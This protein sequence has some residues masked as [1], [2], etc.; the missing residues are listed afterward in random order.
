MVSEQLYKVVQQLNGYYQIKLEDG[1][2]GYVLEGDAQRSTV[3]AP[4]AASTAANTQQTI[5]IPAVTEPAP[6]APAQENAQ[7]PVEE[8][9]PVPE[10][11]SNKVY[12]AQVNQATSFYTAPNRGNETME[13]ITKSA[14]AVVLVPSENGFYYWAQKNV[15]VDSSTVDIWEATERDGS[16]LIYC[17]VDVPL[18]QLPDAAAGKLGYTLVGGQAYDARY[19]MN[20]YY[21]VPAT[22]D[23]QLGFIMKSTEGVFE[24]AK[25]RT[26]N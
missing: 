13:S 12:I 8:P 26:V 15:Y 4:A 5:T 20:D 24:V 14:V 2:D 25:T 11:P 18:L 3:S 1:T 23:G 19:E 21:V 10:V 22:A 9:T 17:T 16:S 7:Q 6:A